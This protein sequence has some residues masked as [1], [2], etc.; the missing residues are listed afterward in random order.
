MLFIQ[1]LTT[2]TNVVPLRTEELMKLKPK[3]SLGASI[4]IYENLFK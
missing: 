2:Y 3:M 4:V 1:C